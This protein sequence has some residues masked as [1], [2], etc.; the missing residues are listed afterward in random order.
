[1][2]IGF[3]VVLV[4]MLFLQTSFSQKKSVLK[5]DYDEMVS[6][7]PQIVNNDKGYLLVTQN[8]SYYRTI[9]DNTSNLKELSNNSIIVPAPA[10]DYFSEIIINRTKG[11]LT[12]NLFERRAIKKFFAV[13]ESIPSMNWELLEETKRIGNYECKK[14]RVDFRGRS[15]TAFYTTQIPVSLGPWKFN[16]LPGL[17]LE[18]VDSQGVFKWFM[19]SVIYPYKDDI[20]IEPA[21]ARSKKFKNISYQDFDSR[22]IESLEYKFQT[23]KSRSGNRNFGVSTEFNTSQWKEPT[24]QWRSKINFT[25]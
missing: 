3:L 5:V 21:L 14:A 6:Y 1:M 16:G 22:L 4:I 11:L 15:Y 23:I 12:E 9:F 2:K 20:E 7:I 8:Y 24:N 25:F 19:K 10:D 18:V 13:D 17:I